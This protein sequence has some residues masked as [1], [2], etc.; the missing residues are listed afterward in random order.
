MDQTLVDKDHLKG[1]GVEEAFRL[2]SEEVLAR[3][4]VFINNQFQVISMV[5]IRWETFCWEKMLNVSSWEGKGEVGAFSVKGGKHLKI[6]SNIELAN[7]FQIK[8]HNQ[9]CLITNLLTTLSQGGLCWCKEEQLLFL[10]ESTIY[11]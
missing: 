10:I 3:L 11:L 2:L 8:T 6:E 4:E 1:K 9:L 7:P 5:L